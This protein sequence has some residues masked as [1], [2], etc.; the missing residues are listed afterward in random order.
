MLASLQRSYARRYPLYD[1]YS[2]PN[3]S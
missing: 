3:F 2:K 1:V